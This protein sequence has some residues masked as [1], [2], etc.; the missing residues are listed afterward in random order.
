MKRYKAKF[1]APYDDYTITSYDAA[2]VV[3]DAIKRVVATGA[4]P[5][6][7]NVRDAMQQT[8][9][10]TLQGELTFDANGDLLT[11]VVSVFQYHQNKA[12]PADSLDA[13]APYVG[14][15]PEVPQT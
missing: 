11:K 1:N 14:V 6:R 3:I 4:A 15:A 10:K 9:L 13:Q 8:K 2:L 5:N 12:G 7:D